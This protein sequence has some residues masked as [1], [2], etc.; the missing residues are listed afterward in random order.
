MS[1]SL[2]SS[3]LARVEAANRVLLSPLAAPDADAWRDLTMHAVCEVLGAETATFV[4][5][6]RPEP[7]AMYQKDGTTAAK[8][9]HFIGSAWTGEGP[10][11]VPIVDLFHRLAVQQGL[12]VWD[13]YSADKLLGGGG[14]GF[15]NPYAHEVLAPEDMLDTNSLF[16]PLARGTAHLA[17]H[18]FRRKPAPGE[19]LPLLNVLLPA[20][21]AG[22]DAVHRL[23]AQRAALDAVR[24]PL[25]VVDRDGREAHR[26]AALGALLAAEPERERIEGALAHV[27]RHLRPLFAPRRADGPAL[28]APAMREVT[29]ARGRYTLR[30]TLLPPG[31]FGPEPSAL[32][33]VE[34]VEARPALP[35]PDVVRSRHGL[36]RREA[37]VAVLLAEGLTNEALADRLFVSKHTARHHVE[38]VLLKLDVKTRA[39]VGARLIAV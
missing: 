5:P 35:T 6:G 25:V 23:G 18:T 15:D 31:A 24:E 16:V 37:E 11:P 14:A 4:L 29:T 1:L 20:F 30:G 34:V 33:T 28:G 39:A 27:A 26:N 36:T 2:N 19:H 22:L 38:A 9:H 7:V 12:E 8:V 32:V 3:A 17:L 13:L 10:G 21:K